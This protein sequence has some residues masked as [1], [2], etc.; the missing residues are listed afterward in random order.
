MRAG[1]VVDILRAED[2]PGCGWFYGFGLVVLRP[3]C[4]GGFGG[5]IVFDLGAGRRLR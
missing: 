1:M 2:V 5:E 3:L 4:T